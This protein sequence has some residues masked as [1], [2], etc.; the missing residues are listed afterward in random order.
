MAMHYDVM[1]MTYA[2]GKV[3]E[4]VEAFVNGENDTMEIVIPAG[5]ELTSVRTSFTQAIKSTRRRAK[6]MQKQGKLYITKI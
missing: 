5:R 1:A 6:M 4:Q 3:Q 2:T